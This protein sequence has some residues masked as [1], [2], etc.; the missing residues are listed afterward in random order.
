MI[1]RYLWCTYLT[2]GDVPCIGTL[3]VVGHVFHRRT[4]HRHFGIM[5]WILFCHD[6]TPNWFF[7]CKFLHFSIMVW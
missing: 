1:S 4:V 3:V 6:S 2:C 5:N 7:P